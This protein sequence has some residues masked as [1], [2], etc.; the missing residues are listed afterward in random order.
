MLQSDSTLP[1]ERAKM[2][3][4][5][6]VPAANIDSLRERLLENVDKLEHEEAGEEWSGVG[7]SPNP[8]RPGLTPF[9]R[10]CSSIRGSSG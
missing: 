5:V 4:R 6:T 8:P 1:I 2:R 9:L 7:K 10:R 3:I